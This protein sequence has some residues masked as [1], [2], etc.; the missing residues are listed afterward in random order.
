M[1]Q[2]MNQPA[3]SHCDGDPV[4]MGDSSDRG[5]SPSGTNDDVVVGIRSLIA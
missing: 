1:R 3:F 2:L 4:Q 5:G